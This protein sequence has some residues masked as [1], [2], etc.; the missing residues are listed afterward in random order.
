MESNLDD[1]LSFHLELLKYFTI[2][3]LFLLQLL[4]FRQSLFFL[5]HLQVVVQPLLSQKL[6]LKNLTFW[7][8]FERVLQNVL[9][10]KDQVTLFQRQNLL[11]V[12]MYLH[13]QL[14]EVE[15]EL[16]FFCHVISHLNHPFFHLSLCCAIF[17][18]LLFYCFFLLI[19]PF[20][21]I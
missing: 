11:D 13:C 20:F 12:Q 8:Q 5:V 4:E 14:H 9:N 15:Y 18:I 6:F 2:S 16:Y 3:L 19:Y 10:L 1:E 7:Y 21:L 17:S